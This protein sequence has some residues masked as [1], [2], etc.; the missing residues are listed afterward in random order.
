MHIRPLKISRSGVGL[1]A[2]SLLFGSIMDQEQTELPEPTLMCEA[3]TMA[4]INLLFIGPSI[5]SVLSPFTSS[6][7][8]FRKCFDFMSIVGV[9]SFFYSLIHK[10]MHKI[11]AL[12]PIHKVHHNFKEV[13]LPTAANAVSVWEFL[14]AYMLPFVPSILLLKPDSSSLLYSASFIS[15][16]NILIHSPSLKDKA[17]IPN[18]VTPHM[19]LNH[20]EFRTSNYSAP[21]FIWKML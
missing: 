19:H 5:Y 12:R 8:P 18:F 15:L 17:W 20:H 11:K 7:K 2:A 1:G 4:I 21:T 14:L 6:R 10:C 3:W 13:V 16:M 9:H